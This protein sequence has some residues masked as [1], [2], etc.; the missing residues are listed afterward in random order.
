[1]ISR[2]KF[3]VLSAVGAVAAGAAVLGVLA[4]PG[5]QRHSGLPSLR[6]GAER[7]AY[8]GMSIDDARFAAAWR[9]AEGN[10]QHFDDIGCMVNAGRKRDPGG[11]AEW[12]VHDFRDQSWLDAQ[13]ATYVISDAI[14]TPMAYGLIAFSRADDAK[15][16][17]GQ[18][19]IAFTWAGVLQNLERKG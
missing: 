19:G 15:A 1:M 6:Y 10:E 2:R 9:D 4:L 11:D 5:E 7:C 18:G 8:C 17:A 16:R 3:I 12:F 13:S 14:K